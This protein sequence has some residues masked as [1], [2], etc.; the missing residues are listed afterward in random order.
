[1]LQHYIS[2]FSHNVSY[3]IKKKKKLDKSKIQ[4]V[5]NTTFL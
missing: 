5:C 2:P 1:M 4:P 3:P